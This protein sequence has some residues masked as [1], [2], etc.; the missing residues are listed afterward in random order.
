[1]TIVVLI[2]MVIAF[3]VYSL[4]VLSNWF[5]LF[6]RLERI[7]L[8]LFGDMLDK[9]DGFQDQINQLDTNKRRDNSAD[10]VNQQRT[11]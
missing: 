6:E 2:A 3:I 5:E 9:S 7:E 10:T 1:M 4:R 8:F 11:R